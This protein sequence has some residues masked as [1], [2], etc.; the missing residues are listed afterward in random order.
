MNPLS[1]RETVQRDQ[2]SRSYG[3]GRFIKGLKSAY[4]TDSTLSSFSPK[5]PSSELQPATSVQPCILIDLASGTS[6]GL[7]HRAHGQVLGGGSEITA[8]VLQQE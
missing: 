6:Q 7:P 5:A 1:I 2:V 4:S 3:L 8:V